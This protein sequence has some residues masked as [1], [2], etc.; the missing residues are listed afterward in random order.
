MKKLTYLLLAASLIIT[1]CKKENTTPAA[2]TEQLPVAVT[3]L[4]T[5]SV[6]SSVHTSSGTVKIVKDAANKIYLVFENFKTD[7]GPDLRV[8]LSPNNSGTPYQEL[9]LLKAA[10][11]NFFYEL[12]A[13][14][15]Y[16]SNNRVLIWCKQFSVLFGYAV[17]L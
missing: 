12:D 10:S 14:V 4:A 16:T 11:G 3:V 8:W 13:S 1:S 5:G 15:N 6:T 17:L 2:V 9:G 7:N